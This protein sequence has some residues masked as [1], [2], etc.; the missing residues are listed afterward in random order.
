[1]FSFLL[2]AAFHFVSTCLNLF[3]IADWLQSVQALMILSV[4]FSCISFLL[5][6]GQ[7]FL[8][9]RGS[10]FYFTGLCQAFAGYLKSFFFKGRLL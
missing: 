5:F 4:V 1:M 7:L 3:V 10:L 6:L 8:L 2:H 9:S